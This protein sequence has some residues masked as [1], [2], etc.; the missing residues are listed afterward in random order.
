MLKGGSPSL[1]IQ[2]QAQNDPCLTYTF[3]VNGRGAI[4]NGLL[5]TF[6]QEVSWCYNAANNHISY[7][8]A[9]NRAEN[10]TIGWVYDPTKTVLTSNHNTSRNP[11]FYQDNSNAV[12]DAYIAGILVGSRTAW[13]DTVVY[14]NGSYDGSGDDP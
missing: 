4:N 8:F 12:F 7:H 6:I 14:S 10:L 13:I 2:L 9:R 5:W 3:G 11:S 1:L